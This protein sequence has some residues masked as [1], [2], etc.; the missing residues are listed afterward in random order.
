M[1]DPKPTLDYGRPRSRKWRTVFIVGVVTLCFIVF[2]GIALDIYVTRS[3][4]NYY[5][6]KVGPVVAPAATRPAATTPSAG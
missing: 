1:S 2:A 6:R 4:N 5:F 3:I